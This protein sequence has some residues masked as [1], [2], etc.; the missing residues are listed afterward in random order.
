MIGPSR[1]P[2]RPVQPWLLPSSSC[3]SLALNL[4]DCGCTLVSAAANVPRS[5]ATPDSRK[6]HVGHVGEEIGLW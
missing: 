6:S 1:F 2:S 4:G 3:T 5:K